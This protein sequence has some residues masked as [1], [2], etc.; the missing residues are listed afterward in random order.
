MGCLM[1]WRG[2][3]WQVISEAMRLLE[4]QLAESMAEIQ[5]IPSRIRGRVRVRDRV[6][7]SL[8]LTWCGQP[9]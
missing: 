3:G 6:R 5:G 7:S 9:I 4:S 1:A 8:L 2:D